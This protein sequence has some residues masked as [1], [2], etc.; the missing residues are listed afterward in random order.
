M[1]PGC[2]RACRGKLPLAVAWDLRGSLLRLRGSGGFMI[3]GPTEGMRRHERRAPVPARL[4]EHFYR[5][6]VTAAGRASQRDRPWRRRPSSG[7]CMG[8]DCPISEIRMN[9]ASST[10]AAPLGKCGT[11][12]PAQ[13]RSVDGVDPWCPPCEHR[14]T[15]DG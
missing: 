15:G 2:L 4:V 12:V 5:T 9:E 1:V 14:N 8:L 13:R 10:G 11:L 6:L 7:E 3:D